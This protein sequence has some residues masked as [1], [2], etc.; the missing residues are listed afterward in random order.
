MATLPVSTSG[1]AMGVRVSTLPNTYRAVLSSTGA[2]TLVDRPSP[3]ALTIRTPQGDGWSAQTLEGLSSGVTY[4]VLLDSHDRPHA[5]FALDA[6]P[7]SAEKLIVHSWF[8]GQAWQAEVVARRELYTRTIHFPLEFALGPDDRPRILWVGPGASF[9]D[10]EYASPGA[11]G[12]WTIEKAMADAGVMDSLAKTHFFLGPDGTPFVFEEVSS[13]GPLL[14]RDPEQGWTTTRCPDGSVWPLVAFQ[15]CVVTQG[16]DVSIFDVL[17]HLKVDGTD[18]RALCRFVLSGGTWQPAEILRVVGPMD[19]LISGRAT[20]DSA[21]T[22]ILLTLPMVYGGINFM[23]WGA[24]EGWRTVSLGASDRSF[25]D[26]WQGIDGQGHVHILQ[27]GG[28]FYSG[29]IVHYVAW[30]ELP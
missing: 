20:R 24:E 14:R 9:Q 19:S 3:N 16:G 11:D 30:D 23:V 15:G 25:P 13:T 28:P 22:R 8:D 5:V 29:G 10:V 27:R 4:D 17:D 26:P 2:W 6:S 18:G 7:G 12:L 1:P 21:G